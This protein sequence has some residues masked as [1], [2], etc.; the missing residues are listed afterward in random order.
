MLPLSRIMLAM[1]VAVIVKFVNG[2]QSII[3][4]SELISEESIIASNK[5]RVYRI[6]SCSSLDHALA[7]LTSNTLINITTDMT[8]SSPIIASDF[9][10]VSIIGHNN[11][12][13]NCNSAERIHISYLL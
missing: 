1:I 10:N 13:V 7:N 5:C 11:P 9:E 4:V 2:Y 12:T 3:H 8:L 6:C